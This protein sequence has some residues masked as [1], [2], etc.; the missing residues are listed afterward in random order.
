MS[1]HFKWAIPALIAAVGSIHANSVATAQPQ[2]EASKLAPANPNAVYLAS[3]SYTFQMGF[4]A[5]IL[6]PTGSYLHYAAQANPLPAPSPNWKIHDIETDYH[7]GFDAELSGIFHGTNSDLTLDWEHFHSEDS[8]HKST[9]S[10]QMI[11]PFF[12]IGPDASPY[13]KARGHATFHF[14]Q[15]NLDYGQYVN[16]GNRLQANLFA[17]VGYARIK[18]TLH[19]RY[20][21][22]TGAIVRTINVPSQFTGAGPQIGLDFNYRIV[23]GFQFV[24]QTMAS[25]FVG[26]MKN[27]TKF[28]AFSPALA[29]VGVTPPNVQRTKVHH[30]TQVVPG[31]EGKLGLAYAY[32]FK[33][34]YRIKLEAGYQA[35][36]YLNAI[37]SA[38][39]GSEV[40]TPPVAPDTVGVYARTFQRVLSNFALA[41][42]Y[43]TLDLGF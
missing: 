29:G 33:R 41:G 35:Q 25:L 2:P 43:I 28:K 13:K 38:D 15:V 31:F 23:K 34:H 6:Q 10:S 24:G 14:D 16:I 12:E 19:S 22:G 20:S 36:I 39:I 7:F 30:R 5:L 1:K 37:Q 4:T 27:H 32:D 9:P 21:D 42:P 17:G 40:V 8:A 11:G 18:E 3:P 26:T